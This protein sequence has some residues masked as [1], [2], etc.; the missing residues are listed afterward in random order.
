ML[1]DAEILDHIRRGEKQML[2][3]LYDRNRSSVRNLLRQNNGNESDAED[4]LQE[5]VIVLWQQAQK[6]EFFLTAKMDTFIY[7][8]ARNLWLKELRR[9]KKTVSGDDDSF[10]YEAGEENDDMREKESAGILVKYVKLL[11]GSCRDI[12]FLFYF[13][14]LEMDEIALKLNFANADTVKAKKYQCKKKLEEMI[15]KDYK[16]EDLL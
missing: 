3:R 6:K 4:I 11:S 12:L 1:S 15:R 7:S 10:H 2:V 13:D 9:R 16:M 8:I 5:A 14:G